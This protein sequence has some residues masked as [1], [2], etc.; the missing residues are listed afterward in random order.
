M[1]QRSLEKIH[2]RLHHVS[3]KFQG[4][5][6]Y[7]MLFVLSILVL[8]KSEWLTPI[9][10]N[11]RNLK[12]FLIAMKWF[13]LIIFSSCSFWCLIL[14]PIW[15]VLN[16]INVVYYAFISFWSTLL[17]KMHTSNDFKITLLCTYQF[18][19]ITTFCIF[20]STSVLKR[21]YALQDTEGRGCWSIFT[22]CKITTNLA[23]ESLTKNRYAKYIPSPYNH[24]RMNV[25]VTKNCQ[26][27]FP[28]HN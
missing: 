18:T 16:Y 4:Y 10:C 7:C 5:F 14:K 27:S 28:N 3:R 6:H 11:F 1:E 15:D 21:F 22:L 26:S 19:T 25:F 12:S 9:I 24:F 20:Q 8:G 17:L 13:Y 2:D 23:R